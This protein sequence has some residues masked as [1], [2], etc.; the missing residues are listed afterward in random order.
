MAT[1]ST[2]PSFS[3]GRKWGIGLNVIFTVLVVLSVVVMV[4]YLS[5]HYLKRFYVSASSKTELSPR[6]ISLLNSITNR[7]QIILYYDKDE[8]FY[9]D[10]YELLKAY[11]AH[12]PEYISLERVDFARDPGKAQ[13]IKTRYKLAAAEDKNLIIFDCED[14]RRI[15]PGSVLPEYTYE[16]LTNQPQ[17][18]YDYK[19][20]AFKGEMMFTACLLSVINPKPSHAYY[21]QGHGEHNMEDGG[22]GGFLKFATALRQNYVLFSPIR[23]LGTNTVPADCNLLVIAG[24]LNPIPQIE[25]DRIEQYLNDGG[26]VLALCRSTKTGLEKLLTRWGVEVSDEIVK[27]PERTTQN[28]L[29]D[30]VVEDFTKHPVVVPLRDSNAQVQLIGPRVLRKTESPQIAESLKVEEVARSGEHAFLRRDNATERPQAYSLMVAVEKNPVKGATERGPTR[31]FVVGDSECLD[32]RQIESGANRAFA[33][34]VFNWMLDRS[35]VL[36]GVGPRSRIEY[37]WLLSTSQ[38]RVLLWVLLGALPGGILLFGG[39]IWIR[40]RK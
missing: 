7:V 26:H 29:S 3:R 28:S 27:D 22:E 32:N 30:V 20:I 40:R 6:T 11:R 18:T 33:N 1:G 10:I 23:L 19:L 34:Y 15:V 31:I 16:Q 25:L 2:K 39:L 37:R 35:T 13:E 5:T 4:N 12:C 38:Q 21:L 36:E 14:R 24:P 8:M 9:N 17:R